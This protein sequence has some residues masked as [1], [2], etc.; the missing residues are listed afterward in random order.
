MQVAP[1]AAAGVLAIEAALTALTAGH[2]HGLIDAA[3]HLTQL[4]ATVDGAHAPPAA[5]V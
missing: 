4:H 5:P 1:I 2:A 3:L